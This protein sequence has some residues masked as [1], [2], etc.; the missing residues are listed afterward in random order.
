MREQALRDLKDGLAGSAFA[1]PDEHD[2]LPDGHD[3][4]ALERGGTE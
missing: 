4:A 1:H 3:V 2:A